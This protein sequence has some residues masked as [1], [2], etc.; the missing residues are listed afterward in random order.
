MCVCLYV[1]LYQV[2]RPRLCT[3]LSVHGTKASSDGSCA[4]TNDRQLFSC[5]FRCKSLRVRRDG[6]GNVRFHRHQQLGVRH[7]CDLTG[8]A[9]PRYIRVQYGFC[10]RMLLYEYTYFQEVDRRDTR[11][12]TLIRFWS[13]VPCCFHY[14]CYIHLLLLLLCCC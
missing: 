3:A 13:H 4:R 11:T 6:S 5:W 10:C 7:F 1:C 8:I 12:A 2:L 14:R 9:G